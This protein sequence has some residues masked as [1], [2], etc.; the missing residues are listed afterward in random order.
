MRASTYDLL[1]LGQCFGEVV[2]VL[3]GHIL[4]LFNVCRCAMSTQNVFRF[5]FDAGARVI[6][7]PT[8]VAS[9]LRVCAGILPFLA[10]SLDMGSF[11]RVCST[12][13][14]LYGY[15]VHS[16]AYD[17]DGDVFGVREK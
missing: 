12:D 6:A 2:Q 14:S 7:L 5:I 9:E 3:F 4:F 16:R 1:R 8:D 15:A 11:R 17:Q 10:V 13:A